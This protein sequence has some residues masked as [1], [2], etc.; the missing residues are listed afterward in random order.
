[1]T[2]GT[3]L[4]GYEVLGPL[5]AGGMGEVYRARDTRL[6]RDVA[7]KVV[8]EAFANNP[9]RMARFQR[10]AEVLA[11]LNHPNIAA[12]YGVEDRALVM[13]LVEGE[14]PKGAMPFEDAW[15]IALQ[16]AAGLEYAH[17][18]G[19]VHR[20][21]KPANIKVTADGV[22]KLLDFGLAKAL[23]NQP[24]ASANPEVSP[25]LTIGATEVGVVLGTAAYM[26]PEQA[27]G[28]SV[29]KRA[30]IW[31]FGVVLYEL[32]TGESLF[33][34]EDVADTLAHVLMQKPDL[35]RVP[36][37]VR[38]LLGR[39]L[40]RD[41]KQRLRDIGE[42]K[43]LLE[44]FPAARPLAPA[45]PWLTWVPSTIAVLMAL[46]LAALAFVHFHGPRRAD[47]TLRYTV[48]APERSVV[49]SFAVSPDGR[50]AAIA[51]NVNG[52]QQLW[53]RPLDALQGRALAT[54]EDATYPFW[55]PDS[56]Y[57]GFFAQGKLKKVA[58]SGGPA[59][60][61]CNAQGARGGSWSREDVIVFSQSGISGRGIQKVSA[62]GG[63]PADVIKIGI[64]RYPAFLPDGRHFLYMDTGTGEMGGIYVASLDGSENRRILTDRSAAVF[65]PAAP[66]GHDGHLLFIRDSVL[67]AMPF[68]AATAQPSGDVFTIAEG[69]G[70]SLANAGYAPVTASENG[71]LLY[72]TE[73]AAGINQLS[74]YD[75]TGKIVGVPALPSNVNMP[76]LSP[77]QKKV[78]FVRGSPGGGFDIWVRDLARGTDTRLTTNSG[79]FAPSWSPKSDNILFTS[80]LRAGFGSLYR[81]AADGSAQPE[82]LLSLP[83]YNGR[84]EQWSRDARF[85]VYTLMD[86]KTNQDIWVLALAENSAKEA[87]PSAFLQTEFNEYQGQLSPDSNWMAYTSEESAQREV[88]VRP[89]PRGEGKW[90]ISTNGGAE[91]RCRGDGRELFY[92]SANGEIVAVPVKTIGLKGS[93]E[94][95]IPVV[96]FNVGPRPTQPVF[97]YDVAPDG[98]HFLVDVP[99]SVTGSESTPL[100]VIVNWQT[101][102][103]K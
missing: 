2:P 16:I 50:Y 51:A 30:D 17:E 75:R 4:G 18:R 74:W 92:V 13:E 93:F 59:Q 49:H 78:A 40:E 91:P 38:K 42:I 63:T 81:A 101:G 14:S 37:Q 103:K 44:D 20:D 21:L 33:R 100:T 29:D 90:N 62:A 70:I 67:M 46:A 61:L 36:H 80:S 53:L 3:K 25:T 77:D 10:E 64:S 43:W 55:S 88:Y 8:P 97:Q 5:G 9:E 82:Q 23:S 56:R 72:R 45:R 68:H 11:S 60:P 7:L 73:S 6:K 1:M 57:I 83:S 12:I 99:M 32:L 71:V 58:V 41:P 19:I 79:S 31:A 89:F 69:V 47:L 39:C 87:K 22:V 85:I 65:A 24:E 35:E 26:A 102:L 76:A 54:T 84:S 66:G 15:H 28:K 94:P 27:K 98:Q 52:R 34:G 96:L 95:G 48:A 86:A